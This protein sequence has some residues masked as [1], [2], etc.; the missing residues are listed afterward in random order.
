M[1]DWILW[2]W[3][4]F[5]HLCHRQ[6]T[7]RPEMLQVPRLLDQTSDL[8]ENCTA[9]YVTWKCR[10]GKRFPSFYGTRNVASNLQTSFVTAVKTRP[11]CDQEPW[12]VALRDS[13]LLWA[14]KA[15]F[16]TPMHQHT[17]QFL[18]SLIISV[19]VPS[20]RSRQPWRCLQIMI[21]IILCPL[22]NTAHDRKELHTC[23]R[24]TSLWLKKS[25]VFSKH[26][27]L[28]GLAHTQKGQIKRVSCLKCRA[29]WL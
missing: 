8:H 18:Q 19:F 1:P 9:E 24:Y 6:L 10:E 16:H 21:D 26:T 14:P 12:Q 7:H 25:L 22:C 11:W 15:S 4:P 27:V 23:K 3:K 28:H 29:V 17:H 2:L 5:N 13:S 20:D